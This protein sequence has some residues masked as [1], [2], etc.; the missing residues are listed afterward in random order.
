M[1]GHP[2]I[3]LGVDPEF[4]PF[5][6]IDEDGQYKGIAADYLALISKKTGLQFEVVKGL[7]WPD[8]YDRALAGD[9]DAMPAIGTL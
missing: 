1:N 6:F 9:I 2:V 5:E 7:T 8:A 3:R 4:V